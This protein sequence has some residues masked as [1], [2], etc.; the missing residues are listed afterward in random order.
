MREDPHESEATAI[1]RAMEVLSE[2]GLEGMAKAVELLMNEAM[3][4]ERTGFLGAA[5]NERIAERAGHTNGFK[6]KTLS[7][8]LGRLG[9][10]IPQ[11]PA[12]PGQEPRALSRPLTL[13]FPRSCP[14]GAAGI[15]PE[16]GAEWLR[17]TDTLHIPLARAIYM[18]GVQ[19]PGEVYAR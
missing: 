8:R 1:G 2:H 7:T 10:A 18:F 11:V 15:E 5:P 17:P 12:L 13:G 6:S 4:L 14:P 9:L 3:K 16:A 19:P